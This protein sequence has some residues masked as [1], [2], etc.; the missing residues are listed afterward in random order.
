M[1]QPK[2][3]N[4][5]KY[6]FWTDGSCLSNPGIGGWAFAVLTP[7]GKHLAVKGA[8]ETTT[9][10]RM[11]LLAIVKALQFLSC[12]QTIKHPIENIHAIIYSDSK[13]CVDGFNSFRPRWKKNNWN[14][15]NKKPVKNK[16]L[17]LLLDE[18]AAKPNKFE[19]RWVKGHND[20]EG[21]LTVDFLARKAAVDLKLRLRHN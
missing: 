6:T 2:T 7:E 21:N 3:P 20:N 8:F 9:N 16:D 10:N 18:E 12:G 11:E 1:P 4:I 13:Y 15:I 5:E 17:W 14:G 19:L